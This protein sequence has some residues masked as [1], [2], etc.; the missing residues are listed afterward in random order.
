MSECVICK[1]IKGEIPN[2][3]IYENDHV[4]AFLDINPHAKGHTIVVP[5]KHTEKIED[6]E[7]EELKYLMEGV[8]KVTLILKEKLKAPGF[9]IGINNGKEAGQVVPHIHWHIFPR[10][11][12]DGGGSMHS[13]INN[14]GEMKVDEVAK[15]FNK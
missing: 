11:N 3:T 14:N 13:I 9:N 6:I 7:N 15:L 5:K 4:L 12:D 10:F 1:I 8:R 2:H